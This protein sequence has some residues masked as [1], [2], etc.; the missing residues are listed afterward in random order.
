MALTTPLRPPLGADDV[1]LFDLDGTLLFLPVDIAALRRRLERYHRR[2][3]IEMPFRPLTDHLAEVARRLADELPEAEARAAIHWSRAQ[4]EGA[5]VEAAAHAEARRGAVEALLE[6]QRRGVWTGVVSNNTR[7]GIRAGLAHVGV[8]PDSLAVIVS[9]Q[10]VAHPKPSPDSLEQAVA[11]L[12]DG[13]WDPDAAGD[14]GARL[15]YVGDAPSDAIA[16]ERCRLARLHPALTRPDC[17]IV[18]GGRVGSGL[19]A[20]DVADHR[21]DDDAALRT[22]LLG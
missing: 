8:D 6:L 10:D 15:I 21:V 1:V 17:V 19:L 14:A 13:G 22:M 12:L 16:A 3:G 9:R 4:V 5:E 2:F 18:G 7:G 11:R 20:G